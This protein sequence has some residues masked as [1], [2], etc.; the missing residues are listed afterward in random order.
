MSTKPQ[1]PTTGSTAERAAQELSRQLAQPLAAGHVGFRT[2]NEKA[3]YRQLRVKPAGGEAFAQDFTPP[4]GQAIDD[5]KARKQALEVL[6][7]VFFN[8]NEFVYVD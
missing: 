3:A 7:R 2:F 5:P 4:A 1:P 8:T 6:C